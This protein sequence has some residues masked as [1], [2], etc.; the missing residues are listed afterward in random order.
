MY[1][2]NTQ[3]LK[4]T[5][6]SPPMGGGW[7]FKHLNLWEILLFKLPQHEKCLAHIRDTEEEGGAVSGWAMQ[8]RKHLR[9][10]VKQGNGAEG[11]GVTPSEQTS[12]SRTEICLNCK[13]G[14]LLSP[15]HTA[16]P[17][18]WMNSLFQLWE[19]QF[20]YLD[21]GRSAMIFF[22]S[23]CEYGYQCKRPCNLY[24]LS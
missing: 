9:G 12:H 18:E 17:S 24:F 7:L 13:A 1:S 5:Q 14:Y 11:R 3:L 22:I 16:G 21:H 23:F 2:I 4:T 15:W 6:T 19:P 20:S 10:W 8:V